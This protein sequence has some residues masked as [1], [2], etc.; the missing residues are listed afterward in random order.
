MGIV[1]KKAFTLV[2]LMVVIAI[3]ATIALVATVKFSKELRKTQDAKA[4]AIIGNWRAVSSLYYADEHEYAT[5]FLD[6][7]DGA[8]SNLLLNTFS[9]ITGSAFDGAIVQWTKTGT[10]TLRNEKMVSFELEGV[11]TS[12]VAINFQSANGQDTKGKDWNKY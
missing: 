4:I 3:I 9:T 12:E 8:D 2:E 7:K 10:A 11:G 1:L 5:S 6:L